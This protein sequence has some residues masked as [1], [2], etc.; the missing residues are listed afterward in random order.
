MFFLWLGSA[1]YVVGD[2]LRSNNIIY[3][4]LVSEWLFSEISARFVVAVGCGSGRRW[5][6]DIVAV[7][8][9]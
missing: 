7:R 2:V 9:R 4:A 3:D 6:S 5:L 1:Q 8:Q